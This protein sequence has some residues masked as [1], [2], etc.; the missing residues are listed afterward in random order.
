MLCS[1]IT[2]TQAG[3][4][5]D[6]KGSPRCVS[7]FQRSC[8]TASPKMTPPIGAAAFTPG[9]CNT[10]YLGGSISQVGADSGGIFQANF[11]Y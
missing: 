3:A 9:S 1:L 7:S 10:R 8:H 11:C 2:V 4:A 5:P 6:R